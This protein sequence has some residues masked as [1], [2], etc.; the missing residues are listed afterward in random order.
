MQFDMNTIRA[1]AR[2]LKTDGINISES[3]LR[4]WVK[5]GILPAVYSGRRAYIRYAK[6]L[7][8]LNTG[9]TPPQLAEHAGVPEFTSAPGIRRIN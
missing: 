8:L 6:V 3:A 4:R 5:Q 1:T 2:R 9:T 7:E